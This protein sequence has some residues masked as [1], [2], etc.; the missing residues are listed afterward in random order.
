VTGRLRVAIDG[1]AGSG[2]STLARALAEELDLPY[3]N[4]G[5]MYRALTRLALDRRVDLEDGEALAALAHTLD[6]HLDRRFHPPELSLNGRRPGSELT[7]AE[8]ERWVSLVS[9]HPQVRRVLVAR[10]RDFGLAGVVMEGRDIGRVVLPGAEVKLYL[11]AGEVERADRRTRERGAGD[12]EEELVRRDSLDAMVNPFEPAPD[13]VRLDTAGRTA[14]EV[15]REALGI[16]RSRAGG[17][18]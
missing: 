3:V 11:D 6:V 5:M 7:A 8:V 14:D 16:V 15:K 10:Q 4:T 9:R 13:A 1:P 2:K 12:L 17:D 18:P